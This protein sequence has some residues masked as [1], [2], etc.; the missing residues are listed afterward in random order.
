MGHFLL[1][2]PCSITGTIQEGYDFLY[3]SPDAIKIINHP[4]PETDEWHRRI[5][6]SACGIEVVNGA[7]FLKAKKSG[8]RIK[9]ILDFPHVQTYA[10]YLRLGYPVAAIG[11]SDAHEVSEIGSGITGIWLKESLNRTGLFNAIMRQRTFATTDP[12]ICI[13]CG[14]NPERSVFFWK[15]DWNPRNPPV[16]RQCT[17]EIFNRD[18]KIGNGE[19]EGQIEMVGNGLYWIA[20]FNEEAVAISSP[21]ASKK[22]PQKSS[23][24]RERFASENFF[25]ESVK[26]MVWLNLWC[27]P[28][29]DLCPV[30]KKGIAELELLSRKPAPEI[31]DAGGDKVEYS[32]IEPGQ[33]REVIKK[34]C[35]SP[36]FDEFFLW[37]ERNEIHEYMFLEVEYMMK[38][39]LF[40]FDGLIVPAKMVRIK[41]FQQRFRQEIP[42]IRRLMSP[43]TSFRLYVRT[44]FKSKVRIPLNNHPFPLQI[45]ESKS[46]INNLLIW[47]DQQ[48]DKRTLAHFL[49]PTFVPEEKQ[50][51]GQKIFQFFL[52][53]NRS[54]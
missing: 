24:Q 43:K 21:V 9:S 1:I 47:S 17:V 51:P 34:D 53:I 22:A 35:L 18:C 25:K 6:P 2:E 12:G 42:G 38:G 52:P 7:I 41:N 40:V 26:D 31:I 30:R 29:F 27:Q 20:A 14:F 54:L 8:Y 15:V 4:N 11:N 44:L 45:D 36:C 49:F 5:I 32:V 16:D 46:G 48:P 10:R 13:R 39:D 28:S 37:L 33:V 19:K 50:E 3:E 23:R